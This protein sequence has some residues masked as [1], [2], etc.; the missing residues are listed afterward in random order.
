MCSNFFS[1]A[2][3]TIGV[4][5]FLNNIKNKNKK[6]NLYILSGGDKEEI[7]LFLKKNYLIHFFKEILASN[8]TKQEHLK[9]KQISKND[10]FIGD[11]KNDLKAS[12]KTGIR[13]VL[14]EEY[15]SLESFPSNDSIN[16]FVSFKSKNFQTFLKKIII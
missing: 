13:F 8:R 7:I 9:N 5:E 16:K 10:I 1:E 2:K 11:S 15:K 6:I 12:L 4:N 14:I 3:P